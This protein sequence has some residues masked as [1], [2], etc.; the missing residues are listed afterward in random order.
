MKLPSFFKD[1]KPRRF[2]FQ[3]RFYDEQKEK[4][5]ARMQE[6]EGTVFMSRFDFKKDRKA[7]ESHSRI[8][9][10][11]MIIGMLLLS[12]FFILYKFLPQ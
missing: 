4:A 11:V 1:N 3:P 2:S 9:R 10:I 5:Q 12:I 6:I 8:K 7:K